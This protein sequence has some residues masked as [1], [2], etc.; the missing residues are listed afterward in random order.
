MDKH[1]IIAGNQY[2]DLE[3]R[4]ATVL[5][6]LDEMTLEVHALHIQQTVLIELVKSKSKL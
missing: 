3:K 6:K 4:L 5:A 1:N 2:A